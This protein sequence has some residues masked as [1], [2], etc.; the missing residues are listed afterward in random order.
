MIRSKKKIL[1]FGNHKKYLNFLIIQNCQKIHTPSNFHDKRQITTAEYNKYDR[2]RSK[3][4]KGRYQSN[5]EDM[6]IRIGLPKITHLQEYA[7]QKD[8]K[9]RILNN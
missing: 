5:Q 7:S 3:I 1:H 4:G 2:Q 8:F 9:I 6:W